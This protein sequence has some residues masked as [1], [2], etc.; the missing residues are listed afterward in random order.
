M[1]AQIGVRPHAV[2]APDIDEGPR[3]NERPRDCALRLASAKADTVPKTSGD[4]VL[5]ADTV[6]ATGGSMLGKPGSAA[7]ATEFLQRLSGRRHRV[8]TGVTVA[9]S[10]RSWAR[11]VETIVKFRRLDTQEITAYIATGE[12]EGKAGAYAIQG[13]AARFIPWIRGSYTNVV[14]LPLTETATLLA[15]AGLRDA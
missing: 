15:A 10:D 6:V 14:G 4:I 11:T 12:W 5:A 3:P 13:H 8:I 2:A 7:S 9:T 1:L